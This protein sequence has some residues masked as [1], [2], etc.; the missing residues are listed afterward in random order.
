M[1]QRALLSVSDKSGIVELAQGLME[2]GIEIISTGGTAAMLQK[3]GLPVTAIELVTGVPEMLGGRVKT[4]HPKVHGGLLARRHVNEDE[5]ELHQHGIVKI[6]LLVVNLY[7]FAATIQRE[8]VTLAEAIEQIDIGGVA[9]LRAGAKNYRDVTV[10]S[11]PADY[12]RVLAQ[13]RAQRSVDEALRAELAVK[14]FEQ[15]AAY[16]RMISTYLRDQ[17][18]PHDDADPFPAQLDLRAE[19][20]EV[21]RYGEN[22][23]Q[24]AAL[25]RRAGAG[26]LAHA[27][28]LHGKGMSYTNWLD[29]EGAW[30]SAQSFEAPAVVIV[31]HASPCGIATNRD[32]VAA[33]RDALASDPISAFGGVVAVNRAVDD[34]LAAAIDEIFT[35]IIL[36]PDFDEAALAR[37][38]GKANRRLLRVPALAGRDDE[39]R[40]IPGGYIVQQRDHAEEAPQFRDVAARPASA[41]EHAALD[42]AWRAVV[43]VKSNA[44]LLARATEGGFAT[45][46]IGTGQ[47]SRVD[48]VA[49]A[50][51]KAGEKAAGS[52][53]A[54]DAFFPFPDGVEAAAAAGVTAVVQ[55]GGSI[56]DDQVIAAADAHNMAMVVTG[57]RHFRH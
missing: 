38:Q 10:L 54:S 37:L 31:K 36:A 41:E 5:Q 25:Y 3:A 35:E 32:L 44:I 23:H 2:L 30:L 47:P 22:P 49:L 29:A 33:W 57:V 16:D 14:A 48:A 12:D 51:Q 26:G 40:A 56:R 13:L 15:T 52:V 42:F 50:V 7:P 43:G 1:T 18:A 53:M 9:L 39:L 28:Q 24:T 6:E 8:G 17:L 27:A 21:M 45:V 20:V 34:A 4:L 46:G 55:P 11:D 19:R